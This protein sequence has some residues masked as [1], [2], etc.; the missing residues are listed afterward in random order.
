MRTRVAPWC[1]RTSP[2]RLWPPRPL[3]AITGASR[4]S[5][6]NCQTWQTAVVPRAREGL[7]EQPGRRLPSLG[8]SLRSSLSCPL[9]G[10]VVAFGDH[11]TPEA[12]E[13]AARVSRVI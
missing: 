10:S 7:R 13:G 12:G 8:D 6:L 9:L 11:Y 3:G 4:R 1:H 5:L 2:R